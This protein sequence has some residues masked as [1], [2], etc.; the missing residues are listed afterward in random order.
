MKCSEHILIGSFPNS[1][2]IFTFAPSCHFYGLWAR[3]K[4]L[5]VLIYIQFIDLGECLCRV[6]TLW[7]HTWFICTYVL[8][9]ISLM[10][11][12]IHLDSIKSHLLVHTMSNNVTT[13]SWLL[14]H[15][16]CKGVFPNSPLAFML[17][18]LWTSSLTISSYPRAHYTYYNY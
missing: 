8:K 12:E 10:D 15:A 2:R 18:P 3:V 7:F 4:W 11:T 6:W 17:A 9:P 16:K 13:P 14:L 5:I 1:L